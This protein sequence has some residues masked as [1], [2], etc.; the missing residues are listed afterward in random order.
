[1]TRQLAL[2][3]GVRSH[4]ETATFVQGA[5]NADACTWL[6]EPSLWPAGR[7]ALF[8]PAG[9]G[10]THL[11]HVFAQRSGGILLP[12]EAIRALVD[13]PDTGAIAIDDADAAPEAEALLHLLNA[14]A[15][16]RLP[17]LLAGRTPPAAWPAGLA[18][19]AS[20][21][22]ATTA[23]ALRLPDDAL[24]AAMLAT[25]L[26]ERQLRVEANVQD[27]L[28]AR[29]PRHG[30]ALR[31]AVARLDRASLAHGRRV[32]RAIAADVLEADADGLLP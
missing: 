12:G 16:A 3:F 24:L 30:A 14:A 15:E 32:T 13:L 2:P 29:L 7:L 4:L 19:L 1:M 31:E 5:A 20:R 18:D 27:W 21:L 23:V 11:L 25:L 10:K 9:S 28:L 17:V 22:R 8:G 26:A 6:D